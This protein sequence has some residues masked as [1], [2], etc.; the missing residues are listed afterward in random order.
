[1]FGESYTC[2]WK[3]W[4]LFCGLD[5]E[6]SSKIGPENNTEEKMKATWEQTMGSSDM[7][8][9]LEALAR[10]MADRKGEEHREKM[11]DWSDIPE[12]LFWKSIVNASG[13]FLLVLLIVVHVYYA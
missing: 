4:D 11:K 9:S 1:M 13:I 6:P 5:T 2:F 8:A 3:F 12:S 10:R 7:S